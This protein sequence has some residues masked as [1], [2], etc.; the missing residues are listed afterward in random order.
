[1]ALDPAAASAVWG[2]G[3]GSGAACLGACAIC[4]ARPTWAL[5]AGPTRALRRPPPE[6]SAREQAPARALSAAPEGARRGSRGALS[7]GTR[8]RGVAPRVAGGCALEALRPA[9]GGARAGPTRARCTQGARGSAVR[10]GM[11]AW[12]PQ[13]RRDPAMGEAPARRP[14]WHTWHR[15]RTAKPVA[16][17][18]RRVPVQTRAHRP[19]P[20]AA[21]RPGLTLDAGSILGA[22]APLWSLKRAGPAPWWSPGGGCF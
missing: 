1:M 9:A 22:L 2:E 10:R 7:A 16:D 6:A 11:Q 17:W 5:G 8:G 20:I 3:V 14:A 12:R 13:A 15:S 19:R 21:P 4:E 18:S